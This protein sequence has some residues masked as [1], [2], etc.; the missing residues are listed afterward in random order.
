M[1]LVSDPLPFV[2]RGVAPSASTTVVTA[3][4]TH[5]IP[6]TN[7]RKNRPLTWRGRVVS[8]PAVR[9]EWTV[10]NLLVALTVLAAALLLIRSVAGG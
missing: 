10:R 3:P 4:T 6:V 9:I 1:G 7:G 8:N 2:D 5:R